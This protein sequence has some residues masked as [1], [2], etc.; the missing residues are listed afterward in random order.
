[1]TR[2]AIICGAGIAGLATAWWLHRDGWQVQLV[3]RAPGPRDEGYMI[4]FFG[5]GYDV[6]ERM[7][8]L[9]RLAEIQTSISRVHYIRPDGRSEGI[10]D[11]DRF[12]AAFDGRGF[13]FLR[14]NLE[15]VLLDVVGNDV[16][17]RYGS[18]IDKIVE[19]AAGV[20][21]V[22]DDGSVHQA[23]L[24]I[25]ADGIHSRVR[26]MTFGLAAATERFLGY[27]TAAYMVDDRELRARVG[28]RFLVIA[29]PDRQVGLY[30][31]TA[32]GWLPGWC[33]SPTTRRCPT[34]RRRDSN[35]STRAWVISRI[36]PSASARPTAAC[37]T[38]R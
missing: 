3:E 10:L 17:I 11:Y 1:M 16:D 38:T 14:G 4:D 25:G 21:A 33:T 5:P 6:A 26:A 7:A 24:L 15:R 13:T 18:T 34:T 2:K 23:D 19:A 37:T 36:A 8:I 29:V 20:E 9:P 31:R 28:N 35:R 22:F 32:A 12:L 27:H 30:P